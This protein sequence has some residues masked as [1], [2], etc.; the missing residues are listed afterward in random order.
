MNSQL[1]KHAAFVSLHI[2]WPFDVWAS[3]CLDYDHFTFPHLLKDS[4]DGRVGNNILL[5][6]RYCDMTWFW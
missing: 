3:A 6:C 2:S 5:R 4:G 1:L